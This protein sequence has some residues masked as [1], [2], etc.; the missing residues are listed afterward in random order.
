VKAASWTA[1]T[2]AGAIFYVTDDAGAAGAAPEG[3]VSIVAS[4]TAGQLTLEPELPMSAAIAVNDAVR[5]ISN[6]QAEASADGDLA[7]TC[8]GI[9]IGENGVTS[10][11]YCWVLSQGFT[12]ATTA[13]S[14]VVNEPV[15]CAAGTV[16]PWGTDGQELQV[17]TAKGAVAADQ[18]A[19][20]VPV[21]MTVFP[22]SSVA[23]A[24]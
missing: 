5:T 11:N 7:Q 9:V 17:G 22:G 6:W 3:E 23:I 10:G 16:G 14:V 19:L 20:K 15:V 4:N 24:P 8:L 18:V 2:Q 1:S 21:I 13:V 12:K